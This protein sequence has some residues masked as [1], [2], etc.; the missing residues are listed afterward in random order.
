MY[1]KLAFATALLSAVWLWPA[2]AQDGPPVTD[3]TGER[4]TNADSEPGNWLSHGR[5]YSEQRF[6]PLD[7][8]NQDNVAELGLAWFA[9]LP[10]RRGIE[11]TPIVVDGRM[12]VSSAW[13]N[14]YA[15][16][17]KTGQQ[18]WAYD[19]GVPR[20]K[21]KDACC[22]VVNR[23]VAAWGDKLYVGTIDGRLVALEAATG[24]VVWE[25]LTIDEEWPYTI[26]GAPRVGGGKV[27]IGNGGAELGVRGYVTAYDAE[28][29]EQLWRFHTVPGDPSQPFENDAMKMAAET[30]T[31][32]WWKYGGGGTVWDSIVYDPDL[33]YFYLGVGNGSPWDRNIRSPEGGDNL[34]LSSI[35]AVKAETGEYVWHYQGTPGDTWDFTATQHIMLIDQEIDG[36]MRKTLV[37]APKNGFFYVI[38]RETGELISANNYVPQTW[39][40]G[41]DKATG[42]PIE[43]EDARYPDPEKP[44]LVFPSP[45]G[46]HNWHP[47]AYSPLTKLVYFSAQEIPFVFRRDTEFKFDQG[48]WNLGT[49]F[50]Y[51]SLPE[52]PEKAAEIVPLL[53]GRLLAWDPVTNKEAF[54]VEHPGPWNGGVLATAGRLVFQGTPGGEFAAYDDTTGEK[55]WSMMAQTGVV[56]GPITYTV[57]DEQYVAVAAGWGTAF[58]LIVPGNQQPKSRVLVFKVGGT[59]KLPE[60]VVAAAEWPELETVSATPDVIA[61]GKSLYLTQCFMCHGDAAISGGVLPDLRMAKPEVHAIWNEI[62]RDGAFNEKGMP[63]FGDIMSEEDSQAIRQYVLSRAHA[64]K[65][66]N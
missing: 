37:Q 9:D 50:E 10:E 20:I 27:I 30:W 47:M 36:Q 43:A 1:R 63:N 33:D 16:D 57:D 19:A 62:V 35:V 42:R 39:A 38:D 3:V 13:S 23:G 15:F 7:K 26:T 56:A 29:G 54:H 60:P 6:S 59:A 48:R 55:K 40:T 28:T 66:A 8:I 44:L 58:G 52:D 18:L 31:G 21:G 17:A 61:H 2:V 34:F 49:M 14:V 53:K 64:T 32:E 5:T 4:I 24:K 45:F 12:Y 41:F 11:A 46:G 22:D 65:P 51:S 25:K